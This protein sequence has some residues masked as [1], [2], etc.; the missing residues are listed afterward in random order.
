MNELEF[1]QRV[2]SNP[3]APDEEVLAAAREN[4]EFQK[5]LEVAQKLD[6]EVNDLVSSIV[7]PEGL[8]NRLLDLAE[9]DRIEAVG[10]IASD[11]PLTNLPD[12]PAANS[13]FF[14]YYA[15]AACLL[16]AVGV[17]FTLTFN[18]GPSAAELAMGNQF[19]RHIYSEPFEMAMLDADN[20]NVTANWTEVDQIMDSTGVRLVGNLRQEDALFYVNPCI[21]IPEYSSAHLMVQGDAGVVSVYVIQNSPVS[22]E[23]Q[24]RDDRFQGVVVPL[25]QGN[26]VIYGED[27]ENLEPVKDLFAENMEWVI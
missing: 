20:S 1:R 25:D 27:G 14:Q 8:H 3:A 19:I 13:S 16:L 12:V 15:L 18:P 10:S 17:T 7:I 5:I 11:E 26:L 23:F 4:P 9:D 22:S 21:V 6:Q 24:I 2:Y